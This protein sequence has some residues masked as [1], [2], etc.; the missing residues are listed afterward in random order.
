MQIMQRLIS[1]GDVKLFPK[2]QI[3]QRVTG[4][5]FIFLLVNEDWENFRLLPLIIITNVLELIE[6]FMSYFFLTLLSI[7]KKE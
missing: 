3:E 5:Y 4:I 6:E 2:L 7:S 1:V